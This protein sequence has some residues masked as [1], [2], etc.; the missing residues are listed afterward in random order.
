MAAPLLHRLADR[1]WT[2]VALVYFAL[3]LPLALPG[4]LL[5]LAACARSSM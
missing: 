5:V 4:F 1:F 2:V 3:V